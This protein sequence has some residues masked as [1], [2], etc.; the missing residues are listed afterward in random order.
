MQSIKMKMKRFPDQG[1]QRRAPAP[2]LCLLSPHVCA[3][4]VGREHLFAKCL[5]DFPDSR[6]VQDKRGYS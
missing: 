1:S 5:D 2:S 3:H 6:A 4:H